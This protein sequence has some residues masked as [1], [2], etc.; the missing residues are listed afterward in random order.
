MGAPSKIDSQPVNAGK[1]VV[2][3]KTGGY[4]QLVISHFS[5]VAGDLVISTSTD[6]G[7]EG[8]KH[9]FHIPRDE[10]VVLP[11]VGPETTIF[12]T[13]V[14]GERIAEVVSTELPW[15]HVIAMID[16]IG[17]MLSKFLKRMM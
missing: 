17:G 16:Q 7:D 1:T 8:L 15:Q 5:N 14:T 13:S 10:H 4:E 12:V 2:L 3:Y 11:I 6:V 9:S